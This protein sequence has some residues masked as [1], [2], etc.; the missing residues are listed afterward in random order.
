MIAKNI[1]RLVRPT[2]AEANIRPTEQRKSEKGQSKAK[3]QVVLSNEA[4]ELL[5]LQR[6][7]AAGSEIRVDR[8]RQLRAAIHKGTYDI[9]ADKIA[10]SM[11][12]MWG[13]APSD[14]QK[15]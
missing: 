12:N 2:P 1:Q 3:D 13:V 5:Q 7:V 11:L 6:Q 8:V 9:P 4:Q 14:E 15:Q 10:W